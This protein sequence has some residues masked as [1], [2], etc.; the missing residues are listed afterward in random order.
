MG[1]PPR[2][3]SQK[4]ML[5]SGSQRLPSR[6]AEINREWI[7]R[8][9]IPRFTDS[10]IPSDFGHSGVLQSGMLY[11]LISRCPNFSISLGPELYRTSGTREFSSLC[12]HAPRFCDVPIF[13]LLS[14]PS[15]VGP[16]PLGSSSACVR[17]LS[18]FAIARFS[19]F[20][21]PRMPSDLG[22]SGVN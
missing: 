19:D 14:V 8:T 22:N 18:D 6:R 3:R 7:P 21:G 12:G 2:P 4:K 20:F 13:R 9:P 1:R 10:R 17:K 15:S 5:R 16:R 11:S